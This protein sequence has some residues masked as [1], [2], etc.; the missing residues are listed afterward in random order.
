MAHPASHAAAHAQ[1]TG[2]AMPDNGNLRDIVE[3]RVFWVFLEVVAA[4]A[5]AV[6]IVWWTFPKKPKDRDGE[7]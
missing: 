3:R 6:A 4:L 5:I 2:P 7:P 1:R